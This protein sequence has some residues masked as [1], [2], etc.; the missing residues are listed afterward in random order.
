MPRAFPAVHARHPLTLPNGEIHTGTVFLNA[1]IDHPRWQIGN[2]SYASS[3]DPP[4]D[5]AMRLA[6]Y[7]Y[8]ASP[9]RLILG[10]FCQIAD[11]VTFVTA[12]ANHRRD[13]IS[14]Y[15][16]AIFDGGFDEGRASLR[17]GA[18]PDTV[19]G[20]DVWVGQGARILPG[21]QLGDGV[22]VGAAAVVSGVIPPYA[23]VAGNPARVIRQRFDSDMVLRLLR[24]AWWE[25][26]IERI[27]ALENE[28]CGADVDALERVAGS[29]PGG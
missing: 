10:K 1:V 19:L 13:G 4:D 12:S 27:L 11:G 25:W 2:Y 24:I 26:P 21:A 18:V 3:F 17:T 16:F 6:P 9:E 15:P 5:W 14:T 20:N 7:L 28:I 29:T 8:E 23:V 22:I